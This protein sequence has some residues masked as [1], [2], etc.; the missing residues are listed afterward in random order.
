M[1]ITDKSFIG[2]IPE[3]YDRLM[4]P[5]IFEPYAR[6]LAA[7]ALA[8]APRSVLEVAAGTGAVTRALAARLPADTKL[9]ATDLNQPM[10]DQARKQM[11]DAP[12][13]IFRQAD[14]QAL[15]F[16]DAQFDA[17]LCQFGAM[18]FPDRAKAYREAKRVLKPGGHYLFN[19]WGR[20]EDNEF[21]DE[22]TRT[23]ALLFPS[24]PPR[25]LARTPHGYH[26][27]DRIRADLQAAAFEN[28]SI[29]PVEAVSAAPSPGEAAMAYC[30]GTPLRSE[31]EARGGSLEEATR[32]AAE[33][34]ARR[35]GRGAIS[36]RI[37]AL[38]VAAG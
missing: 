29:M 35:F 8:L 21:A 38:V 17:V 22:V 9:V 28:I 26:D 24:D 11:A 15:P 25:F 4:V 19:V 27:P 7:R 1:S 34:L 12:H 16:D 36:G 18:F 20:I 13:I 2:S 33:A 10:L 14:A 30:Q 6:D 37:Q 3:L 31:I 32:T 5:L 23:L